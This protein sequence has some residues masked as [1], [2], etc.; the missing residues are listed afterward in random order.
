MLATAGVLGKVTEQ[1]YRTF[2]DVDG[3]RAIIDCDSVSAIDRYMMDED[4][5]NMTKA[6][7]QL[8]R[9]FVDFSDGIIGERPELLALDSILVTMCNTG[10]ECSMLQGGYSA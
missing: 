10:E 9:D 3:D 4:D 7:M 2:H 6:D 1:P 5:S 8:F